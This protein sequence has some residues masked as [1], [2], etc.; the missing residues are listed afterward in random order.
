MEKTD[1]KKTLNHLYKPSAKQPS[2]VEAPKM[3]FLMADGQGDP[4]TTPAFH[5]AIKALYPLAYTLKFMCKNAE[6]PFD[7]V[8]PP[9]EALWWAEDMDDFT[10]QNKDAWRWTIMIMQPE[11][12]TAAMV[13]EAKKQVAAKKNPPVLEKVR[14]ETFEEGKAAQILHIGP[15]SEEGPT[16]EKL[17]AFIAEQGAELRGKHHEIYLSDLRRA[18]PENWKTVIRQPT[19]G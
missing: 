16:I 15:F 6:E 4:N 19:T 9:M 3:N 17:H 12:V 10:R 13:E 5:D 14:F 18:A 11:P 2:I 8:V 1:F 7:Y